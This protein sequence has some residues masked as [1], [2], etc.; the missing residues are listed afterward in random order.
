MSLRVLPVDSLRLPAL[1][2]LANAYSLGLRIGFLD[3][4]PAGA[5][6]ATGMVG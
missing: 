6:N 2:R 1:S 5:S 3:D 4:L